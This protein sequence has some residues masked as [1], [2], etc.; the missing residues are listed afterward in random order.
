MKR[1]LK[2]GKLRPDFYQML[3][4]C[5]IFSWGANSAL[6][7]RDSTAFPSLRRTQSIVFVH[8]FKRKVTKKRDFPS[9]AVA[10]NTCPNE[11][12]S[13]MN[14]PPGLYYPS[15]D[16]QCCGEAPLRSKP[17]SVG[18]QGLNTVQTVLKENWLVIWRVM[19]KSHKIIFSFFITCIAYHCLLDIFFNGDVIG[20]IA[21]YGAVSVNL[22]G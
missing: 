21:L 1:R 3:F 14:G 10:L 17:A 16:E 9:L 13:K 8:Q 5:T 2:R 20:A 7:Q 15:C 11:I 18:T 22:K 12:L 19:T 6:V 4:S